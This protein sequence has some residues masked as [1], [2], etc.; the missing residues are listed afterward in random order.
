VVTPDVGL[1]ADVASA[2]AGIVTS[3]QPEPLA[4][5][6]HTLLRDSDARAEMGRRGRA[7]VEAR[8]TWEQVASRMEQLYLSVAGR[9]SD[10]WRP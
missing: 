8:F 6:I 3:N 10:D 2:G 4:A 1:A 9:E 7:L 5:A